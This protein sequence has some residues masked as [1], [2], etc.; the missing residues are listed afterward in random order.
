MVELEI[1]C[2]VLA[3]PAV[4]PADPALLQPL[5]D[6][7][8][9]PAAVAAIERFPLGTLQP[10]GRL[11]LC[12][13][14]L[15][16]DGVRRV[17]DQV[18]GTGH[19]THLLLGT[20]GLGAPG[21]A[22]LAA[23]L[24]PGHGVETLYLGCNAIDADGAAP[25]FERL[26]ADDTVTALWLKRN[27]LGDAGAARLAAMLRANTAITTLDL[28]NTGLTETGLALLVDALCARERPVARVFLGGNG[29]GPS[30]APLLA[31]LLADG[32]PSGLFLAANRLGDDGAREVLGAVSRGGTT[33]GLGG[34]GLTDVA[35]VA[36]QLSKLDSLDLS[37]PQSLRVLGAVDN[38]V[39]D[40]GAGLLADAL[41]DSPL[42]RLDLRHTGVRGRGAKRLLAAVETGRTAL[43]RL[44]LGPDVPRRIKRALA[45]RLPGGEP[46]LA[47]EIVSVYR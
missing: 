47:G 20:N 14:G 39:G 7:L 44:T 31:R 18:A 42:R 16:A 26:A 45:E 1:S 30:A 43:R 32:G 4:P 38:A 3:A 11:D 6:R 21:T 17:L 2:P 23:S 40:A 8:A 41:P 33:L 13:Q 5:L 29:L 12:K 15:G 24:A 10:D 28:V 35:P 27:P 22:A 37:R 36:A 25:L 19:A 34:N 46:P 9:D